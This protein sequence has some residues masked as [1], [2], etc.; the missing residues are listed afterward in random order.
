MPARGARYEAR[1]AGSPTYTTGLPCSR[2]HTSERCTRDG[3]CLECRKFYQ[4]LPE[5][6]EKRRQYALADPERERARASRYYQ[7]HKEQHRAAGDRWAAANKPKVAAMARRWRQAN[8]ERFVLMVREWRHA[9]P[10][11]VRRSK[12]RRRALEAN[13]GAFTE[14]AI[15]R[16]LITQAGKCAGCQCDIVKDFT[17]DH[18]LPL[19]RGGKSTPKN[20]QLLCLSCNSSKGTRTNEEWRAFLAERD[21]AMEAIT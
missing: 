7:S 20:L 19:T 6:V 4:M 16:Q 11:L 5:V 2:G 8:R 15:I 17:T 13:A 12:V 10:E 14:T 21:F 3:T 1:L 9:N 18:K